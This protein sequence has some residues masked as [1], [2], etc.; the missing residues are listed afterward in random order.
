MAAGV[1][2][3][4]NPGHAKLS[5]EAAHPLID[6]VVGQRPAVTAEQERDARLSQ[7]VRAL[8]S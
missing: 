8:A 7:A 1:R 2:R 5:A 4:A 6:R 3:D